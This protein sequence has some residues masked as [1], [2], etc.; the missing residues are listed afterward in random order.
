MN[1]LEILRSVGRIGNTAKLC[2]LA[3]R[4]IGCPQER[5]MRG[6]ARD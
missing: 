3:Q 2:P 1:L 5:E 6:R 4:S